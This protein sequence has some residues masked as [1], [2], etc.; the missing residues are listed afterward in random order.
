M[1]LETLNQLRQTR[2]TMVV[3]DGFPCGFPN[4]LLRVHLRTGNGKEHNF[5]VRVI[6][7]YLLDRWATMP[8]CPIPEK[9]NGI[10]QESLQKL[11]Q[12]LGSHSE[13]ITKDL[14]ATSC[15]VRK[16]TVP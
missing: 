13:F 14:M 10:I 8:T 7:Q 9:Q 5:Q 15:P 16:F 2:F 6:L 4:L 1:M 3:T 11:R 12:M